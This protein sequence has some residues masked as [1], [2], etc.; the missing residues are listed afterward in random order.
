MHVQVDELPKKAAPKKYRKLILIISAIGFLITM[1]LGIYFM[2]IAPQTSDP[3]TINVTPEI[4]GYK[5]NFSYEIG[6]IPAAYNQHIVKI[7]HGGGEIVDNMSETLWITL[8]PPDSTPYLRR[9]PVTHISKYMEFTEGDVLY[10]YLGK[11]QQFYASKELPDYNDYI[12]FP[13]GKW[14]VH[15]DDARYKSAISSYEFGISNS[16]THLVNS[17]SKLRIADMVNEAEPFDTVFVDGD[18]IYHEQVT[19]SDKPIRIYSLNGATI[20]A[21]GYNSVISV[22]NASYSEIRG[23]NIV[24][25]GTKEPSEAGILLRYSDHITITNNTIHNN[26]NG[27]YT[28]GSINNIIKYNQIYENDIS[29]IALSM[30]SNSNTVKENSIQLNTIGIYIKDSS[31]TNYIVKN[32]GHGNTRY[33]ILIDNK[34]KNIYEYNNFS[35][36]KLSYDKIVEQNLTSY[37]GDKTSWDTWFATCGSHESASSPACQGAKEE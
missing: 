22:L 13:N 31:D 6:I 7:T 11:D 23:F 21:G 36:D 15:I 8:Y 20:D 30:G 34:L 25:S 37:S 32:T 28:I 24:S 14:G 10:I 19:I 9:T 16:K 5:I 26:Q 12:D 3:Q 1:G 33:G 2:F 18:Q 4:P 35:Y 29:G 17:N 27:I